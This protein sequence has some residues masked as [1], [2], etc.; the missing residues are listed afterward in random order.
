MTL[1]TILFGLPRLHKE[2][3][4]HHTSILSKFFDL[5]SI[6]RYFQ[7][8]LSIFIIYLCLSS[9]NLLYRSVRV[10]TKRPF[11]DFCCHKWK[12]RRQHT[13][14]LAK[15]ANKDDFLLKLRYK[16][17]PEGE[18]DAYNCSKPV[19]FRFYRLSDTL[20]WVLMGHLTFQRVHYTLQQV[21]VDPYEHFLRF[22]S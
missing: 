11:L 9:H 6:L 16:L 8:F 17:L 3:D 22:S 5:N 18:I 2:V 12:Y 13:P 4:L 19:N 14:F 15:Y 10:S 7:S 1:L 20:L 21:N